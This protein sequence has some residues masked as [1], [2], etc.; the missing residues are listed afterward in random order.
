MGQQEGKWLTAVQVAEILGV[1]PTAIP[2]LVKAGVLTFRK[3]SGC[4]ARFLRSDVEDLA[5]RSTT[6]ADFAALNRKATA[7]T[8][9]G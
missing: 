7:A 6:R 4:A 1:P 3:L 5:R 2:R 8:T 9:R